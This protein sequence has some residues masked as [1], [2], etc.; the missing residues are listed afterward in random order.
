MLAKTIDHSLL[1]PTMTDATVRSGVELAVKYNTAT[2]CIKP[3]H[4]PMV[5][6]LLLSQPP[7]NDV[8]ICPV[9]AFP[10]GNSS[11]TVKA[12]EARD[13]LEAIGPDFKCGPVEVDMVVNV[14]KVLSHDWSYVSQEI[15][16]VHAI[17][18]SH[19][20]AL[21]VIFETDFL[22][23]HEITQ[24][25][26]ICDQ[27]VGVEFVKTSTGYGFVKRP[28]GN[29]NYRGAT[30]EN[31][32][33]MR[34]ECSPRVALKAAGGVR[35]LDDLLAVMALGV[36]RIGAT[37]TEAILEEARRRGIGDDLVEVQVDGSGFGKKGDGSY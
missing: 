8:G 9:I 1:H 34:A 11:I 15:S 14:G 27:V 22:S 35:T 30:A 32:A 37:A 12:A 25:C 7:G 3:Y 2:A 24:L 19:G 21:K 5:K 13:V 29:Y 6:E 4:V 16:T 17:T 20:A 26:H 23:S 10:H 18:A 33:L 31:L 28:D 36:T